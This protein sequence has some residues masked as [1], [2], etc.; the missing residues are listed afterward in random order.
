MFKYYEIMKYNPGITGSLKG[1]FSKLKL[2]IFW[3]ISC[4]PLFMFKYDHQ[5]SFRIEKITII[6][7]TFHSQSAFT[8]IVGRRF[9]SPLFYENQP[10]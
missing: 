6:T 9:L 7:S 10:I 1:L 4:K 5:Y 3:A 8:Y 2:D